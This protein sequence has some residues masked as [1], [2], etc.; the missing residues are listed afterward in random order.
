MLNRKTVVFRVDSSVEI[1][2]GHL[3]R[4]LALAHECHFQGVDVRFICRSHYGS[5]HEKVEE[6]GYRLHLLEGKARKQKSTK[7]QDWLGYEQ[8]ADA[9]ACNQILEQIPRVIVVVDH[10]A[11]DKVWESS[12]TY[13]R[14]VVIDDLA[15]RMHRSCVLIDQSL[16]NSRRD[17]NKLVN[18]PFEFY[19]HEKVIL[20]KEFRNGLKWRIPELKSVLV[21]MGG[22]DPNLHTI[23]V[24]K[25][26][27]Y[28]ETTRD[29]IKRLD[30]VVGSSFEGDD[31]LGDIALTYSNKV[32]VHRNH[33]SIAA[34]ISEARICI[35]S[36]GSLI[37]EACALGAPAIGI[38][39]TR[40]QELA[41]QYLSEKGAIDILEPEERVDVKVNEYLVCENM[42]CELSRRSTKAVDAF[43]VEKFVAEE[44]IGRV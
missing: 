22:S 9:W 16:K 36:C 10:Y 35:L 40:D 28:S 12:V 18:A 43:F 14:L 37:L 26:L 33:P 6:L 5:A 17:Y 20:R 25:S 23:D 31:L 11:L 30:I 38:A 41:A 21:C 4:C 44:V 27:L 32:A 1:G 3:M 24:V 34:A 15:N 2:H 29:L 7:Y 13:D 39:T 42:C 8:L 19:G